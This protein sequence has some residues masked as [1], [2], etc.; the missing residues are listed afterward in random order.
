MGITTI[1]WTDRSVNPILAKNPQ[2]GTAG[3]YCEKISPGCA[4]CY[5]SGYQCRRHMPAFP[6][7]NKKLPTL[8][9]L[10]S[11]GTVTVKGDL[12]VFF[13][14]G[15]LQE[16]L[17]RKTPT[18]WFWCDMSDLFGSWV[19]DA[20]IDK[21]F[22]VMALTPWH[23]HQVLTKRPERMA[24]YL[25]TKTRTWYVSDWY[26]SESS[27]RFIAKQV[28]KIT[29]RNA[30][31][32]GVVP[33]HVRTFGK[34]WQFE[35][36]VWRGNQWPL[37]NVWLGTSVESQEFADLR[38]PHLLRCP[39]AVRFLSCEPLLGS[40]DLTQWIPTPRKATLAVDSDA[41]AAN[42]RNDRLKPSRTA[43]GDDI[44][45]D[46]AIGSDAQASGPS[47]AG[48][49]TPCPTIEPTE[50]LCERSERGGPCGAHEGETAGIHWVI[51][52]GESGAKARPCNV[53]W[54]RSI[55]QQC[56]AAGLPVFVKQ[57]GAKPFFEKHTKVN[58]SSPNHVL[59]FQSH[60]KR[61]YSLNHAKG[62][63]WDEWTGDLADLRV[64]QMP[65]VAHA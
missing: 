52:G 48:A 14:E 60:E 25:T 20:W 5:S 18:K 47:R 41:Y 37:P 24:E 33:E 15:R 7:A 23:T 51:S 8:P 44:R 10:G 57:L 62:G 56:Q 1:E 46:A 65:E 58:E 64:R 36:A 16:V 38:I 27:R 12:R 54:I 39:A 49:T 4:N 53:E 9:I 29:V 11:D 61:H 30:G 6:G 50:P 2:T 22:A 45:A 35:D 13:D 32:R 40:V 31:G 34:L 63:D 19:P 26:E 42:P 17:L 28:G 59:H 3:H 55:V 43:T 21:C